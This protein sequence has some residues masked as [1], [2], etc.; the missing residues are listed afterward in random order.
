TA[1]LADHAGQA[2][3]V[4][5]RDGQELPADLVVFT[6]GVRPRDE[7][8][9]A[10]G[11][12]CDE[13]GGARIDESCRTSDPAI[14]AIGEVASF[15]GQC[16]GLVAPGYA[17]AEVACDR[18]LGGQATFAGYDLSTKLKLSGVDVASFGDAFATTP[19]A[20]DVVYS[21]PVNG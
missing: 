15:D 6:V 5:L 12:V 19:G 13:R 20:L 10:A 2:R 18:I 11:L 4:T 16:V 8:A 21:D 17:M 7:L 1:V 3:A 14:W 9:R